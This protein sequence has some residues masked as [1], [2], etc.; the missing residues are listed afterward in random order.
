MAK[1]GDEFSVSGIM[2]KSVSRYALTLISNLFMG[3]KT[4]TIFSLDH[5][6]VTRAIQ[7]LTDTINELV[8]REEGVNLSLSGDFLFLNETRVKFAVGAYQTVRYVVDEFKRR[9]L[10]RVTVTEKIGFEETKAFIRAFNDFPAGEA[11]EPFETLTAVCNKHGVARFQLEEFRKKEAASPTETLTSAIH[12][13]YRVL[14]VIT[15][16]KGSVTEGKGLN[17][18][19]AKRS[20]QG[21]VDLVTEDEYAIM[22]MTRLKRATKDYYVNHPTNVAILAILLGQRLGL[23]KRKLGELGMTGLLHDLGMEWVDRKVLEKKEALTE[24]EWKNI[25]SH[26]LNGAK[27]LL[28]SD[29]IVNVIARSMQV[30][31]Q[32]QMR[33][34]RKGYPKPTFDQSPN[35]F[36]RIVAVCDC[37]DALTSDRPYRKAHSPE[38]ALATV[39]SQADTGYD[40]LL[41]KVFVSMLGIYPAGSLVRL[42]TNELGIVCRPSLDPE[43][44]DRPKVRVFADARGQGKDELVDLAEKDGRGGFA[45]GVKGV[46]EPEAVG[47]DVSEYLTML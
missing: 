24:E 16:L 13:Y 44:F 5:E 8:E 7:E 1:A 23:G 30:S 27:I 28:K 34:D 18:R 35:L 36:S 33:L 10:G 47:L 29:R 9:K 15:E 19:K 37:Y 42:S 40:G 22:S 2:S 45:R 26:P 20:V 43:N 46:L 6:N 11:A 41:V 17:I 3:L 32:H 14:S 25:Q 12:S 4:A 38:E 31:L 39:L 21:L